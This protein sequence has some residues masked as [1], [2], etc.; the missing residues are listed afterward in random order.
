MYKYKV[1]IKLK[2]YNQVKI[3]SEKKYKFNMTKK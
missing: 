1:V 3:L 2:R